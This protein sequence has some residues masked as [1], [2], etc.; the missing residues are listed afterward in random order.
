MYFSR[1]ML[2]RYVDIIYFYPRKI[3]HYKPNRYFIDLPLASC[4]LVWA[5]PK[6][7]FFMLLC[8]DDKL[9][10]RKYNRW[11]RSQ[12]FTIDYFFVLLITRASRSN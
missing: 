6:L 12:N 3:I 1:I 5:V 10:N 8:F 7:I 4:C 2:V 11:F 9:Y